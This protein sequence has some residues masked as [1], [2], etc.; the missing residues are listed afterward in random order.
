MPNCMKVLYNMVAF[1]LLTG[2]LYA[3]SKTDNAID[4]KR[5]FLDE[6][7]VI[8]KL[9]TDMGTLLS[10]KMKGD[11]V[12]AMF[13][14]KLPDGSE[15][16]EQIRI[17]TRGIFR[18]N[19]CFM[20]PLKLN[21]H[22]PTSPRLYPLNSLKLTCGCKKTAYYDQLILKEYLVYKMYNLITDK[23]FRVRLVW[24]TIE[25]E[26]QKKK[27]MTQYAFF[28]EDI[29]SMAKRNYCKAMIS[30]KAN[31]EETDREQMTIVAVFQYMIGNTDWA[32]PV[33]HNIRLISSRED[34]TSNPFVV[35]YDFDCSG[36]VNAEYASPDPLLGTE[37]VLERVYRGFPRKMTE[38]E[39]VIKNFTDQKEKIYSL[40]K[41]FDLLSSR[42]REEM[43]DYLD[44]F[45]RQISDRKMVRDLFI[46][47]ARH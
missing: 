27:P 7:P 5:F 33:N 13:S 15:V 10:K 20:P 34:S 31:T 44:Q 47:H 36:L 16:N 37:T 45:Y 22:N 4:S 17:H 38:L 18:R 39:P 41:K 43:I 21:F 25:D 6:T 12:K 1:S 3:Q 9:T 35:A 23:S 19:Y 28:T 42:N 8:A 2:S 29:G 24:L 32:V 40:V 26:N 14:C 46:D 30:V 11:Y